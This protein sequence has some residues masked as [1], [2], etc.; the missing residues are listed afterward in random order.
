MEMTKTQKM[1]T[2]SISIGI[3]LIVIGLII[4]DAAILGNLVI[5]ATLITVTPYFL[6]RYSKVLSIK[7]IE[8]QFP[9]FLRDLS[10]SKRSGMSFP[11]AIRS[12]SK[13]N[14]GKLTPEIIKMSN[15]LSW[16]IPFLRVL[17]IFGKDMK[18]SK[19]I[20]QTLSIIKESYQSG[21]NISSTL[22]SV[23]N[24]IMMIKEAE[25]EQQSLTKQHV[26]LMYGLFYMFMAVSI[27]IIFVM[28]PMI[29]STSFEGMESESSQFGGGGMLGF[30]FEN[31][32]EEDTGGPTSIFPCAFYNGICSVLEQPQGISCYYVAMFFVIT[33]VQ[34]IFTGLIA[35]QLGEN[36]VTA[37][38]KHS[39]IMI[40]SALGV[41]MFLTKAGMLPT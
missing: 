36:S 11:E 41:F 1:L 19:I 31:P 22:D 17:D 25:A 10:D 35:G 27:I 13:S 20:S 16:G 38:G 28:V 12:A 21:G 18:D 29:Q 15:R 24:D 40:F 2:A 32:C 39:L 30:N 26:M 34:G 6:L 4:G 5:I 33:M 9:N 8:A 7:S 14:Y 37:G 3:V 23:S